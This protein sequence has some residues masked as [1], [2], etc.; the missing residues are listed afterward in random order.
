MGG[1]ECQKNAPDRR[2]LVVRIYSRR[3]PG[4]AFVLTASCSVVLMKRN[5]KEPNTK[6][7]IQHRP[8]PSFS[9]L[10]AASKNSSYSKQ[11]NTRTDT[12][13]EVMLR[14]ALFTRGLRYRK[15]VLTLR[16][17][18][19]I[20]FSGAR[21]VV[22]CDGDFWHGRDWRRLRT[23]LRGGSNGAYWEQKIRT[24]IARDRATNQ[25]LRLE[26]WTVLRFW[27]ADIR[28]NPDLVAR[29]ISTVVSRMKKSLLTS[30]MK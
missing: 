22:F 15:N 10:S 8:V 24:N 30:K 4:N 14:R 6:K 16:G 3:R 18:P 25:L 2:F 9:G 1:T 7:R 20:V 26:G 5:P 12:T 28:A 13:H 23:K 27:E 21:V 29:Q 17:K 11:R 19:D